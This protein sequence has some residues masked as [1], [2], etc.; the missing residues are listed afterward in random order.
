MLQTGEHPS[1]TFSRATV[2]LTHGDALAHWS[3]LFRAPAGAASL[4][5]AAEAARLESA[6]EELPQADCSIRG[7]IVLTPSRRLASLHGH[8]AGG[9]HA[10]LMVQGTP[11]GITLSLTPTPTLLGRRRLAALLGWP[12]TLLPS[13]LVGEVVV[14][15]DSQGVTTR[16]AAEG[17]IDLAGLAHRLSLPSCSGSV[18][19][20]LDLEC[21]EG[22]ASGTVAVSLADGPARVDPLA[23]ETFRYVFLGLLSERAV[24][25]GDTWTVDRIAFVVG[26][27]GDRVTIE[28]ET[29][30][31]PLI[32]GH[33]EQGSAL[34]LTMPALTTLEDVARR[35]RLAL[36][37]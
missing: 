17:S 24:E 1:L 32:A 9:G 2:D 22:A 30:G 26:F 29:E 34:E 8:F 12:A 20:N 11:G 36:S 19:L 28:A 13:D 6:P 15:A 4:Q 35:G 27:D 37:P 3:R 23:L 25:E 7:G 21:S 14:T 33:S 18:D 5:V 31:R 16:L 10:D